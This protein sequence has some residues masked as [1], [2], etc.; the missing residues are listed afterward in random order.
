[1]Q[2]VSLVIRPDPSFCS[3]AE[4][5]ITLF[6]VVGLLITQVFFPLLISSK[7]QKNTHGDF[8]NGNV[9]KQV[10]AGLSSAQGHLVNLS[11]W[12]LEH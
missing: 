4:A 6:G 3:P 7:N 11:G 8:K 10:L 2:R 5:Q 9:V 1:M 12:E